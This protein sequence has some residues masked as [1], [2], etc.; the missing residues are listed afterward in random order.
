M[1]KLVTCCSRE[2]KL[3]RAIQREIERL[4]GK[5]TAKEL[6]E[7]HLRYSYPKYRG[8]EGL[9]FL[10]RKLDSLVVDGYLKQDVVEECRR[11]CLLTTFYIVVRR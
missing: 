11:G 6:Q 5:A 8:P 10:A 9:K 7:S 3:Q 2:A 4:G 1:R